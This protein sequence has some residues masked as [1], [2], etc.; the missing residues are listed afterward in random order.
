MIWLGS[1]LVVPLTQHLMFQRW[2][3]FPSG[4]CWYVNFTKEYIYFFFY[5]VCMFI[6]CFCFFQLGSPI[7]NSAPRKL[8]CMESTPLFPRAPTRSVARSLSSALVIKWNTFSHLFPVNSWYY[9][10]ENYHRF[11]LWIYALDDKK[12]CLWMCQEIR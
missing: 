12:Y 3:L 9:I 10:F 2:N 11:F 7:R 1:R 4:N 8:E 6:L 5:V